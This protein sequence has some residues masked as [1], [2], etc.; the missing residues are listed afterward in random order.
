LDCTTMT[1]GS[2]PGDTK[3]PAESF[4]VAPITQYSAGWSE[5]N[6]ISASSAYTYIDMFSEW[7]NME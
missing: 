5:G 2:V 3:S 6:W 1:P 7:Q 4:I